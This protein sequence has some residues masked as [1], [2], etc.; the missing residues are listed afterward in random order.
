MLGLPTIHLFAPLGAELL[1][2]LLQLRL[3]LWTAASLVIFTL[4]LDWLVSRPAAVFL[5][6]RHTWL[7]VRALTA[8]GKHSVI[9]VTCFRGG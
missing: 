7:E 2:N 3:G 8:V 4:S 9:F 6:S 1:L 5:F